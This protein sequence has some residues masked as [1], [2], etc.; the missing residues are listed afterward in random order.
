MNINVSTLPDDPEHLKQIIDDLQERYYHKTDLSLEQIRHLRAQL[1]GR[2]S[3]KGS[4]D[5]SAQALP[6]FDMP[7]PEHSG[8]F[9]SDQ[10]I[11]IPAQPRKKRGRKPLPTTFPG[12]KSCMILLMTRRSTFV[13]SQPRQTVH[14]CRGR[15]INSKHSQDTESTSLTACS[16]T[17]V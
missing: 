8:D 16:H 11:V 4:A 10:K 9:V 14:G 7:E 1:F 15:W 17:D 2:K 3:E 12:L 6:P 13:E 5:T